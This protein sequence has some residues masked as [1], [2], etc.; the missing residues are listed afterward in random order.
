M[1]ADAVDE[2]V[3]LDPVDIQR[4]ADHLRTVERLF[5]DQWDP[6]VRLATL[7]VGRPAVAEELVA[8]VFAGS[9][10]HLDGVENPIGYLR[11]AVV[12]RCRSHRRRSWRETVP[13]GEGRQADAS[14]DVER[15]ELVDALGRLSLRQRTAVVLFY[16]LDLS[17][18]EVAMTMSCRPGT[19]SSL[20][21]RGVA[22]LR[23]EMNNEG[24]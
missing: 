2:G 7:I 9:L 21:H 8:D 19:V 3:D 11:V 12:N 10:R 13:V 1:R 23:K 18:D 15:S 17:T 5:L 6:L 20:L 4:S 24:Q 16:W 22:R 14:I